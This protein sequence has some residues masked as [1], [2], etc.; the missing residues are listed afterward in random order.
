[1][2]AGHDASRPIVITPVHGRHD[3]LRRLQAGLGSGT[4]LPEAHI[5]VAMGDPVLA[6]MPVTAASGLSLEVV[7]IPLQDGR[8]PLARARNAGAAARPGGPGD[9]LIFLDVDCIP[10]LGLVEAY[11]EA[12]QQA[13]DDLLCGPV[14]YL[15]PPGPDGYPGPERLHTLATPHPARPAPAPG[16]IE[17]GG[18]H[19]L[20]WSLSFAVRREVWERLGGF[21]EEFVGYGAEDTDFGWRARHAGVGLSWIGSARA[22]H[23]HH[24]V[25]DPPVE[26]VDDIL[27]NGARFAARWGEWPMQGWLEAFCQNGL[28]E[29]TTTGYQRTKNGTTTGNGP[30]AAE[31]RVGQ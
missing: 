17:R 30:G 7:E 18:N 11:A 31:R 23:Q 27:A 1:M 16:E 3:H 21:D 8:L 22:Y 15:P 20:F 14:A 9:L 5:V 12:S 28:V 24:P 2:P 4:V 19:S 10:A 29:R 25:S 13:P 26:H 6:A